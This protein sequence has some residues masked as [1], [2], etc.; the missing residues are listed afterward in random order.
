[1][2]NV[3]EYV[4]APYY[5]VDAEKIWT[6]ARGIDHVA[7]AKVP[8]LVLHPE[9]EGIIKVDHARMLREAAEGNDLVRVWILPA[10]SHGLLEAADPSWT[11]AVYRTFFERW[12]TY[13]ERSTAQANGQGPDL[14]YSSH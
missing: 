8:L 3:M 12:A 6:E 4:S 2:L 7:N 10:G 13:A 5:R 1:M 11:H 14:V 9:D